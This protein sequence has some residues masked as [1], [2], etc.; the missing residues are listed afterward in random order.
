MKLDNYNIVQEQSVDI[1]SYKKWLNSQ[2]TSDSSS[3]HPRNSYRPTTATA[4]KVVGPAKRLQLS[5][6]NSCWLSRVF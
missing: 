4:K 6:S 3:F 5:F 1:L 2:P